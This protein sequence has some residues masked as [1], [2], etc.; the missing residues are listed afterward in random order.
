MRPLTW[1][2]EQWRIKS[3]KDPRALC[4]KALA[5][6]IARLERVYFFHGKYEQSYYFCLSVHAQK[7]VERLVPPIDL[8]PLAD[9]QYNDGII[10]LEN[11]L[12]PAWRKRGFAVARCRGAVCIMQRVRPG[13]ER[14]K[15]PAAQ[16]NALTP[17]PWHWQA[18]RLD[19]SARIDRTLP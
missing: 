12:I 8:I 7:P 2:S 15:K 6:P 19:P 9:I 16:T 14:R 17:G 10:L 4:V 13:T 5:E 3:G 11:K 1:G 18:V